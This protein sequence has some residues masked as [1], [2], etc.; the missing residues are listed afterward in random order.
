MRNHVSAVV[1]LTALSPAVT[2]QPLTPALDPYA[3]L[4]RINRNYNT[5]DNA[6]REPDTGAPRGH[7]YCSGV[8]LRMV[9]DGPFNPWDYSEF[10]KKTGAT[11][12]SWIRRDLSING[13]VRPAGFILRT[14]RDAHALGLPVMETGFMC[15]YS[16]DG[17]TGPERRWHGCGSYN[18][19]LPND[20]QAKS[21]TVPANRNQALAWG[22]CDSLGID[23]ANQWRQN[24]R[25]VRTDMNRIQ[26]AQCSWNIEQAGDWDAM[27]DTHQNPNVRNDHFARR[28]LSNEMMLRNASE[29]GDGSARLPYID[30][31]V[32]DVNSTYVAPT[33]GDVK[34]PTPVVGLEPARNFQR[35]LYAQGYAVPILRLDFKKP[36]SERFSYAPEDQ[37]IALG[38]QQAAPHRYVQSADWTLRLDPGTGRQEWTL[39]VVPSAQG[40][41]I[42]ASDPQALY[43][44]LHALRGNDAQWQ[45]NERE[46]GSMRQQLGCLIDNYPANNVWNLEPFRPIVSPAEAARAG[47]NPFTA[48]SSPLIASSAWSQF[49]D[50]ASGQ[51]VWGLR[52]VPTPAGRN[53]SNEALYAELERLRGQDREWQEGG[54]GSM[55]IQLAC[56]QNNYRSKADWNLEP[57]RPA[58][59]AAQA[60][61]QGCNPT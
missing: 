53:A 52:V 2:A 61:A 27:I 31:F 7:Y 44:E 20:N 3:T 56:L 37:V 11:S 4:E 41:A 19:P 26:V 32:W 46:P 5:L 43:D 48:P 60:K 6:C 59:T 50:G 14:P 1:L 21:A 25:F 57:Y 33:R 36:A 28:E 42:Q 51:Q 35:K 29:D 47:C 45:E 15:I 49:T 34:R 40:Q 12:Y 18:Q 24:Y 16:F 55:R 38:D 22:S 39:S 9:D 54:P 30:A 17:F 10:A 23:T 8:T 13:L 58:V